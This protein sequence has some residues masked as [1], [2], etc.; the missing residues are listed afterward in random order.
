MLAVMMIRFT[1]AARAASRTRVVPETA[2]C[3][4]G[5]FRRWDTRLR[6]GIGTN[7]EDDLRGG[8]ADEWRCDMDDGIDA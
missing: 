6:S 3:K 4:S 7:L 1:P 5:F 8:S 2:D